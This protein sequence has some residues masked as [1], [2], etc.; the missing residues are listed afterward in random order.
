MSALNRLLSEM[1]RLHNRELV[2][3]ATRLVG[4]RDNGEEIAQ[5]AYM[6]VAGRGAKAD[7][8]EYPKSYL[9]TTARNSA[10]DF[11]AQRRTEW[12]HRVDIEDLT[13]LVSG[14]DPLVTV[15]HRQRLAR[16]AVALNE[17]PSACRQTFVMNKIEGRRHNEIARKLGIS[18]SMVEKH[19][20]RAMMH[21]RD[22]LRDNGNF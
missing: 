10:V 1:F 17:L 5:D 18:V 20:M 2:S 8:I 22:L 14:A 11:L 6:R 9:F 4:S 21:C 7:A 13:E 19:M 12:S 15:E 3:F 16:L